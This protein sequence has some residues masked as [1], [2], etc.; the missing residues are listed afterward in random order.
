MQVDRS[1]QNN[2]DFLRLFAA[3]LVLISHC[4]ALFGR[5]SDEFLSK[6]AGFQTGG[7]GLAVEIFFFMSGFL[8][9][10]SLQRQ[11][12]LLK[13][14]AARA[15]RILPALIVVVLLSIFV[16]GPAMTTLS[17]EEYASRPGT[18]AYLGNAAIFWL[19]F[20]LPGVFE[21]APIHG[22]N[23]SLWTLPVEASMYITLAILFSAN[24][25]T[26]QRVVFV[27]LSLYSALMLSQTYLDWSTENRGPILLS[28]P[29][30]DFFALGVWFYLGATYRLYQDFI[31]VSNAL[32]LAAIVLLAASVWSPAIYFAKLI[33]VSYLVYFIAFCSV[34]LWKLTNPIGDIS[35]GVYIY[36]FPVQQTVY[37]LM[38]EQM[39][40]LA[41][42]GLSL[43][44]AFSLAILSWVLIERPML[45]LKPR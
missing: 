41:M 13:F 21:G 45:S 35:Y 10:G 4:Y 44:F 29:L 22:V 28:I 42:M 40:F 16:L 18:L 17:L 2:F 43:A 24:V 20:D 26:Q 8:L 11:P 15:L 34:P 39:S 23:G 27:L 19:R 12:D 25:I 37:E 7:G 33:S 5:G 32:A 36:A 6:W 31:P 30:Y 3:T 9:T 1:A 38:H 14:A